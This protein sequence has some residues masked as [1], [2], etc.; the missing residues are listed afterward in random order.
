MA[1]IYG[2][3]SNN[4]LAGTAVADKIYGYDGNDTL[5]GGD[6]ADLLDGGAGN[7]SMV[8]GLG[9]DTYIIDSSLD[10]VV[11]AASSGTD[12]ANVYATT[13]DLSSASVEIV[14]LYSGD[15]HGHHQR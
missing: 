1:T 4:N 8:G 10:V 6:G 5:T 13:I 7:D 12:A 14:N 3:S 15:N 11:E 2:N 9:N